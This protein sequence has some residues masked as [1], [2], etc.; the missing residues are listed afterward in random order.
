MSKMRNLISLTL[1]IFRSKKFYAPPPQADVLLFDNLGSEFLPELVFGRSYGV[2]ERRGLTINVTCLLFACLQ[3]SFWKGEFFVSYLDAY[4]SFTKP[5]VILT[6]LDND[7]R[8]LEI[9]SRWPNIKT[10]LI[11]NGYR[12]GPFDL[13]GANIENK[14]FKVDQMYTFSA[15]FK[16]KYETLI[17][18]QATSIGSFRNNHYFKYGIQQR[19]LSENTVLFVSQFF[20]KNSNNERI[21]TPTASIDYQANWI[22]EKTVLHFLHSWCEENAFQLQI[23]A[24]SQKGLE[25]E[26]QFFDALTGD[27]KFDLIAGK[28]PG[29]QYFLLDQASIVVF[30]DSSLGYESIAR[31]NKTAAFC[32]RGDIWGVDQLDFGWPASLKKTGPFW[33]NQRCHK[34]FKRIM[35]FL[36]QTTEADWLQHV[37]NLTP[38]VVDNDPKNT[39]VQSGLAMLLR[40]NRQL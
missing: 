38:E 30:I 14:Q 16:K 39:S 17:Q 31:G 40:S 12:G 5:H 15:A 4:I 9:S 33:T 2:F 23:L 36:K 10:A 37:S 1:I 19:N 32:C 22:P 25:E 34:D 21:I 11:Q 24:R 3:K 20:K 7:R 35:G 6:F 13:F 29:E 18:G 27:E 28:A 26:R 8:F